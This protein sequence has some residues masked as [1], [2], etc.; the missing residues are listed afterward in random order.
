MIATRDVD[1]SLGTS[2]IV[3]GLHWL[4]DAL[5]EAEEISILF[6][7]LHVFPP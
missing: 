1:I 4:L 7:N 2:L 5:S 6:L 3:F